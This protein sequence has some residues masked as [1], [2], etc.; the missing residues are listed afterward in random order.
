[1]KKKVFAIVAASVM[2]I[3]LAAP[4]MA[5]GPLSS[6]GA[7]AGSTSAVIVDTPEGVLYHSLWNC[8]YKT[9]RTLAEHFGD[10]NGMGQNLVGAMLG[11]PVGV[12]WGVPYGAIAGFRHGMTVGWDKPFSTESYMVWEDDK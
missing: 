9:Q 2:A 6:V 12:V 8:P 11:I 1:M 3:G 4:S 7:L 5:D 10:S